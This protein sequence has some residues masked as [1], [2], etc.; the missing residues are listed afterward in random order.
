[1]W[2]EKNNN[3]GQ[4]KTTPPHG[5]PPPMQQ[6]TDIVTNHTPCEQLRSR[7]TRVSRHYNPSKYAAGMLAATTHNNVVDKETLCTFK[8]GAAA[9]QRQ[10]AGAGLTQLREVRGYTS[11]SQSGSFRSVEGALARNTERQDRLALAKCQRLSTQ[12]L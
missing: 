3:K 10:F 4:P 6:P 5:Q 8:P 9:C 12:T 7:T 2:G 11:R 1:M